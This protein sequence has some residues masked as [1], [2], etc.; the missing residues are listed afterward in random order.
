[1]TDT[2]Q[3]ATTNPN[4][5]PS[6]R[7]K[8]WNIAAWV[9]AVSFTLLLLALSVGTWWLW[10][11]RWQGEL[12]FHES[13]TPEEKAALTEFD[14]YLRNKWLMDI[15]ITAQNEAAAVEELHEAIEQASAKELGKEIEISDSTPSPGLETSILT[16]IAARLHVAPL[17]KAIREVA[18]SG[19][20]DPTSPV[21]TYPNENC[22]PAIM[23]ALCGRLDA[24]RALVAHGADVTKCITFCNRDDSTEYPNELDT[25]LT[26]LLA[27]NFH[28]PALTIPWEK[29][30]ETAEYL[31]SKGADLNSN[32]VGMCCCIAI[33]KGEPEV[34][35]WAIEKGR[36]TTLND[37]SATLSIDK[38]LSSSLLEKMLESNP[39]LLNDCSGKATLLQLLAEEITRAGAE[40]MQNLEHL[41][42]LALRMGANPT[43][44]PKQA[45]LPEDERDDDDVELRLPLDILLEKRN[46]ERC[47]SMPENGC[48][49]EGDEARIIWERM[50]D[51]LRNTTIQVNL[52]AGIYRPEEETPLPAP[53]EYENDDSD[54]YEEVDDEDDEEASDEHESPELEIS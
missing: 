46:F 36:K 11:W 53:D 10:G 40:E 7:R 19:K 23:A 47:D 50:C 26:P 51:M 2:P 48:C 25:P 42:S 6:S 38:E 3:E 35:L 9:M 8:W 27:G 22:T 45:N 49:G 17:T 1:M 52:N 44:R 18:A 15:G 21:K 31:L 32:Y 41:L 54:A 20:G 34:M 16:A 43:I 30:K 12:E 37:F 5:R 13:W 4:P 39:E 24:L 33:M 14:H 29:R 28:D